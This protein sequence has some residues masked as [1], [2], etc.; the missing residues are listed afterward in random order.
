MPFSFCTTN[1]F[2]DGVFRSFGRTCGAVTVLCVLLVFWAVE[3]WLSIV[4][5]TTS[6]YSMFTSS[7]LIISLNFSCLFMQFRWLRSQICS[8][9]VDLPPT[10]SYTFLRS[11]H[12]LF[13]RSLNLKKE[14]HIGFKSSIRVEKVSKKCRKSPK[15]I[16]VRFTDVGTSWTLP[17]AFECITQVWGIRS[18]LN[19]CHQPLLT[20]RKPPTHQEMLDQTNLSLLGREEGIVHVTGVPGDGYAMG[21]KQRILLTFPDSALSTCRWLEQGTLFF[22]DSFSMCLTFSF[23][24]RL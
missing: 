14:V 13:K 17:L 20:I 1:F 3:S 8:T 15:N 18:S 5:F 6:T 16:D 7:Y 2:Y 4:G 19:T 21:S 23:Q 11:F 12:V 10:F 24:A 9:F 22:T